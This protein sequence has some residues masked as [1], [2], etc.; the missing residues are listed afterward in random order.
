MIDWPASNSTPE[1]VKNKDKI[2]VVCEKCRK[3][4]EQL[5][6]VAKRKPEH[7]CMSCVKQKHEVKTNTLVM[8]TCLDCGKQQEQFYRAERFRDWRCHHCAMVKGHKDGKFRIVL[9]TPSEGGRRKLSELAK[10]RWEDKEYRNQMSAKKKYSKEKR[11]KISKGIWSDEDRL[12]RL[13]ESIKSIWQRE[14]YRQ[15]RS[16][17]S[18]DNW[19]SYKYRESQSAGYTELVKSKMAIARANQPRESNIQRMLYQFLDDLNVGYHKEG[20][21]TAIGPYVFD[22]MIPTRQKRILVE[23]QGD[24]WHTLERA[25]AKDKAKFTYIER[26]FPEYEI[27]YIWEH[28]FYAKD[29]VIGRLKS[30][31]GIE[32]EIKDFKFIDLRISDDIPSK[33][34]NGFLDAYHY[35]GKGR[36][37]KCFGAFLGDDLI[38]CVVYSNLVRQ[39][40]GHQFDGKSLELARLCIHPNYQKFNLASYFVSK[41]FKLID[42]DNVV[43]YCDTTVGHSGAVYKSLGFK[44]H[45]EV[46]PDYWYVDENGWVMHK[47]T[48]YS[49]AKRLST[50]ES[51]YAEKFGYIKKYGGKKLCFVKQINRGRSNV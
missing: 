37:G 19:R 13:K 33:V 6:Q 49:R 28:E 9:N 43:S 44:L 11:S 30:K 15:I 23:C 24:Y 20:E 10:A 51:E 5:Y 21:K 45:H 4:R 50:T 48:L 32:V 3:P 34:L 1:T 41:T 26:Y 47:K 8:Y 36:S 27:M 46:D 40:I 42:C 29:K 16:G 2:I 38:A 31:L 12:K 25:A 18:R 7:I 14:E 39:N 35:I 22:C 17:Q